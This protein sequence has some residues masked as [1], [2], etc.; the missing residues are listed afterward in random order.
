M[1]VL[2]IVMPDGEKS[3]SFEPGLTI[4]EILMEN[5]IWIKAPCGGAGICGRCQ[6]SIEGPANTPSDMEIKAISPSELSKGMRLACQVKPMG[7][8]RLIIDTHMKP[9]WHILREDG[10]RVDL[11]R[12][13]PLLPEGCPYGI[14]I[15]LG[16]TG[17]R[18]RLWDMEKKLPLTGRYGLNPQTS[19]GE[20]VLSRLT[21]AGESENKANKLSH[22]AIN[23]IGNALKDM[24]YREGYK[25]TEIGHVVIVGNTAML[26]L[27]AK[28]N[29]D[30]LLDPE[31]WM[32]EIDCFPENTEEWKTLWN[33]NDHAFVTLVPPIAGFVGS[34]LLAA[35]ISTNLTHE[36]ECSLLIDFGTNSEIALWDG[37]HLLVTSAAGGPAFEGCGI[38]RGMTAEE[39]AIFR[40]ELEDSSPRFKCHVLGGV[41]ARGICGSALVDIIASMADAGLLS[42]SGRFSISI[43]EN[44]LTILKGRHNIVIKKRDVDAFQRA[45]AAVA[46]G[47]NCLLTEA[48]MSWSEIR[49]LYICGAFGAF[50]NIENGRRIGLLPEICSHRVILYGNAALAGCE[51]LLFAGDIAAVVESVKNKS[52]V[53][54]LALYPGFEEIFIKNLY[55]QPVEMKGVKKC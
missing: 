5:N 53:I 46:A 6:V 12:E 9:L 17:M 47:V 14:A 52:R 48:G 13:M 27:L 24:E 15:D 38:I 7:D 51:K 19:F 18:F 26:S 4:R 43:D 54:N 1:A 21:A 10:Y 31:Y 32:S 41:E 16:T 30:L 29:Y 23:S 45:K 28:K 33:I 42:P 11:S 3:I 40:V 36:P 2:Y 44:G 34:D 50:L 8:S 22:M 49:R 25:T 35:L 20:D 37:N 39:G 55:L